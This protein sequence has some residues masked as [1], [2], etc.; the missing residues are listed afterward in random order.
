MAIEKL[1]LKLS[2]RDELSAE[3]EAALRALPEII[4]EVPS[5]KTI[6]RAGEALNDSTLLL[7]GLMG[8]YKDL[9]NGSRQISELHVAGDFVDLHSFTLK[10]LD[11]NIMTLTPCRV[12]T[13]PHARLKRITE[14]FPH[15]T[16]IL[17][18]STNLDAAIHRE[19]VLSLGRRTALARLAHFFCELHVRL[20]IV[21]LTDGLSFRLDL[22]QVD[23]AECLG[24]TSIHV[25][26]TLKVLREQ[27]LV[28]LR[29]GIV[30]IRDLIGLRRVAEFT[31]DYLSLE[32]RPR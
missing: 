13:V 25:N 31:D 20:G 6:I 14:E 19:W 1:L 21:G 15:L 28:E 2:L 30:E 29:G 27:G 3:E 22:T 23:I 4:K 18:F 11:H 24:L 26:R 32:R 10:R 7:E 9:K 8:R 17:W 16:R 5:D 12:A